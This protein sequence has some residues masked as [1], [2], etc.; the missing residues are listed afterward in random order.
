M[1]TPKRVAV[2]GALGRMGCCVRD[3]L[4][5]EPALVLTA[6]LEAPGHPRLGEVIAN[7]VVL[8]DDPVRALAGCDVFIDFSLPAA[9]LACLRTASARGVRAVIGTTGFSSAEHEEIRKLAQHTAV[10]LSPNFSVSVHVMLQLARAASARLGSEF[11]VEILELHHAAKRDAPSGTA[12]RLAEAIAQARGTTL[13]EHLV[14]SREGTRGLRPAQAIGIQALRGGDNPGEHT[15]LWLGK[16]ERLE[17]THRAATRDHFARG[18]VRAA[19][20]LRD[21]APGLYDMEDVLGV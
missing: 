14:L 16:G 11:D 2:T 3:A 4:A 6:A 21:R 5:E 19:V 10:V 13:A 20:W 9:T 8:S 1:P 17:L 15:V 18:A 12:L 7:N